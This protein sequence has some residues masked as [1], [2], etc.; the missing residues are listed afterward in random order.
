MK[1]YLK[2]AGSTVGMLALAAGVGAGINWAKPEAPS[3]ALVSSSFY[4]KVGV[5][6]PGCA[7]CVAVSSSVTTGYPSWSQAKALYGYGC[8]AYA[9]GINPSPIAYKSVFPYIRATKTEVERVANDVTIEA[10]NFLKVNGSEVAST[11]NVKFGSTLSVLQQTP[12]ASGQIAI[13]NRSSKAIDVYEN[14]PGHGYLPIASGVKSGKT[15]VVPI[16]T[17]Y[18]VW[19]GGSSYR[20]SI[21]GFAASLKIGAAKSNQFAYPPNY[22][23][24]SAKV[25]IS[26]V[27]QAN[28]AALHGA[29]L[30]GQPGATGIA[31]WTKEF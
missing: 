26:A 10:G 13:T 11:S 25:Q 12:S 14:L 22:G 9:C 4:K 19:P 3:A 1:K 6:R 23:A 8:T 15:V 28:L 29:K 30:L 24:G 20:F 16:Q 5:N 18:Q 31:T 2:I 21:G 7:W 17:Q 27:G